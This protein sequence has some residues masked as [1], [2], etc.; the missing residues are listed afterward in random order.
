M[1]GEGIECQEF[2]NDLATFEMLHAWRNME[3]KQVEEGKKNK[4]ESRTEEISLVVISI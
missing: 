2:F 1:Q 3:N 4:G